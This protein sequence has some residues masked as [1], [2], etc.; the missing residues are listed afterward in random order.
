MDTFIKLILIFFISFLSFSVGTFV[1]KQISDNEYREVALKKKYQDLKEMNGMNSPSNE[2]FEGKPESLEESEE[3]ARLSEEF[4]RSEREE[5][6][7]E[8]K[9]KERKA[10]PQSNDNENAIKSHSVPSMQANQGSS[11]MKGDNYK[12]KSSLKKD[13]K[14][15]KKGYKLLSKKNEVSSS[16][17]DKKSGE[18][19]REPSSLKIKNL[20]E[21]RV[22][23]IL[24]HP[25]KLDERTFVKEDFQR[26][27][28][29]PLSPSL[30]EMKKFP[31]SKQAKYTLQL[32]AYMRKADAKSHVSKLQSKGYSAFYVSALVK[33]RTW[34]RVNVGVFPD[35]KS[36]KNFQKEFSTQAEDS[37]SSIIRKIVN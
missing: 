34:H 10:S 14:P 31:Y 37:S 36:A 22:S 26:Q 23:N 25:E 4:I 18:E 7:R 12:N 32:A 20:Q 6:Q 11:D 30:K 29:E 21:E 28:S 19:L 35:I 27:I 16:N 2:S 9:M 15:D 33:G 24:N 8:E 3:I 5:T 13:L 1:G 17:K